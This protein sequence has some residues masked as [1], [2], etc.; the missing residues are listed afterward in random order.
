MTPQGV[1][2]EM[3]SPIASPNPRRAV[4]LKWYARAAS[5][6][7]M[8][9]PSVVL[10]GWI[11]GDETLKRIHRGF[12]AMNPLTAVDFILAGV[13]LWLLHREGGGGRHAFAR[14]LGGVIAL[15]GLLALGSILLGQSGVDQWL[16]HDRLG[17]GSTTPNRM[18]PT[19]ATDF[20]LMGVALLLV[21][22]ESAHGVRPA[23]ILALVAFGIALVAV[24]GYLYGTTSLY[25][26]KSYIPMALHTATMFVVLAT[27]LLSVRPQRGLVARIISDS[28]GGSMVRRLSVILI[29][30]P[31]VLGW[32]MLQG[33]QLHLYDATFR[34]SMFVVLIIIIFSLTLWANVL[35]LDRGEAELDARVR[36]RT[37]DLAQVLAEIGDGIG[38]LSASSSRIVHSAT[39]LAS[40]ATDTAAAV[41]ET[42][43]TVEELRQNA[44]ISSQKAQVVAQSAQNAA[45]IS[46]G[47]TKSTGDVGIGMAHIHEQMD[48]IAG[49]MTR[50]S[51]QGQ[52]IGEI[53]AAVDDLAQQSNLL[54]VNAAIEAAKA[55]EQGRGFAVV[56][57]EVK[58]L[59]EQSR[60]A[61]TQVRAIL[62][63]IQSAT[64]AAVKATEQ[65]SRVV[66]EGVAQSSRAGE[67]ILTLAESIIQA[68]QAAMQIAE[69]SQDQLAGMDQ[70]VIAMGYVKEGS[71]QNADN[72]RQLEESARTLNA[73]GLRLKQLVAQYH[74]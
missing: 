36:E 47:G 4:A 48:S 69:S 3:E 10:V 8:L 40:G 24:T 17:I 33:E 52:A 20:V 41:V 5:I 12:V 70:V 31:L 6:L 7:L 50:L 39:Q 9:L 21:D 72:A 13:A 15:T 55:G 28:A 71:T 64:G 19:T 34:F 38:V 29:G 37:A 26:V 14:V 27:G 61:T 62:S 23:Q 16:F 49:S 44:Q 57:R 53:I 11:I 25:Q 32:L 35:S 46:E 54:A 56:A 68:S 51:E 18:S 63:D 59:A 45:R 58:S 73:L 67:S 60:Q 65:G 74:H 43:T 1:T 42:T 30:V 66:E 2:Q 22:A